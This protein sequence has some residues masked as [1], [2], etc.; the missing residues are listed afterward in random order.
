MGPVQP[1]TLVCWFAG[2][3]LG[4]LVGCLGLAWRVSLGFGLGKFGL[5]LV[6]TDIKMSRAKWSILYSS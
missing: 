1:G 3:G 4:R 6:S 5:D 2:V